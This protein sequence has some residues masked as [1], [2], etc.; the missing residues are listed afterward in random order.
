MQ[1][2]CPPR[3]LWPGARSLAEV[4]EIPWLQNRPGDKGRGMEAPAGLEDRLLG[5]DGMGVVARSQAG[6]L[7][8]FQEIE[9]A[10]EGR[11]VGPQG[12]R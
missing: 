3:F 4:Q 5:M 10:A 11:R 6:S 8:T 2:S 12:G 9:G 1:E 7:R